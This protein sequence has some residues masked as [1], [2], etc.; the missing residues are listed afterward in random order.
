[1]N[2]N[3]QCTSCHASGTSAYNSYNSGKH[4]KHIRKGFACTVCHNTAKMGNHF[5]DLTTP[6]FETDPA[7]TIGGGGTKVGSYS[8]GRCSSIQCHG[9][10]RWTGGD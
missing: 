10:E 4:S 9:S 8:S 1:I 2:V 3:S 6:G 7:S 5:G